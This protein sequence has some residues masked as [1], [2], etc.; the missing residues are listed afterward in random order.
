MSRRQTV[1][2]DPASLGSSERTA[3]VLPAASPLRNT[4]PLRPHA[5]NANPAR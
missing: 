2:T 1:C 3:T 5:Q 4:Q